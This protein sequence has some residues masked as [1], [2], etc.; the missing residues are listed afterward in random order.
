MIKI[1]LYAAGASLRLYGFYHGGRRELGYR[2]EGFTFGYHIKDLYALLWLMFFY[3]RR[4]RE[5]GR[6]YLHQ[7]GIKGLGRHQHL[8]PCFK[9]CGLLPGDHHFK[10]PVS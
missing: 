9:Y 3:H 8:V 2:R 5:H 6:L 10:D 7:H 1:F 4:R